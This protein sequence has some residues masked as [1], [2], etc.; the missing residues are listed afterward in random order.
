MK[1][2]PCHVRAC[3]CIE[4][5]SFCGSS[6]PP[7]LALPDNG[8]FLLWQAQASSYTLLS[9]VHYSPASSGCFHTAKPSLLPGADLWSLSPI[10][11]P[12]PEC[13]RLWFTRQ[14]YHS[15][16]RVSL[17][18]AFFRPAASLSSDAFKLPLH[19]KWFSH[20]LS[21]LSMDYFLFHSFFLGVLVPSWFL[22]FSSLSLYFYSFCS[23]QLCGYFLTVLE[24][25]VLLSE[26]SRCSVWI[27]LC[28][29]VCVCVCDVFVREGELH[30]RF[31]HHLDPGSLW[32][33]FPDVCSLFALC[34]SGCI[35]HPQL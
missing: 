28:V 7:A 4:K 23:T 19:S 20:K 32:Q 35:L 14:C 24:V 13:L 26:S 10:A 11:Q 9:V 18:F 16:V 2:V 34:F 5:T 12:Y 27:V 31:L 29:V 3:W 15:S 22:F 21:G 30:I 6:A 8:A 17:C 1:E 25:W 33:C